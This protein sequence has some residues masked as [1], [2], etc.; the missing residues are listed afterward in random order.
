MNKPEGK[1]RYEGK[2][3]TREAIDAQVLEENRV[4]YGGED[5]RPGMGPAGGMESPSP[6]GGRSEWTKR[7]EVEAEREGSERKR[8]RW[9]RRKNVEVE[10]ERRKW[11]KTV[12]VEAEREGSG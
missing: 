6:N 12:E 7:V 5:G 4:Q 1:E 10:E 9:K 11:T 2:K 8:W 3:D